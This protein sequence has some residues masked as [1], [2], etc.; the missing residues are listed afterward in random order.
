[1]CWHCSQSKIYQHSQSPGIRC[2]NEQDEQDATP[3][4]LQ[5]EYAPNLNV[6]WSVIAVLCVTGCNRR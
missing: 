2:V 5:G 6:E 4:T 1:M 3:S